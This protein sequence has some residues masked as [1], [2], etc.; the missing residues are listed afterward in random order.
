MS[1]SSAQA[2]HSFVGLSHSIP[3]RSCI[4]YQHKTFIVQKHQSHGSTTNL[5]CIGITHGSERTCGTI[6]YASASV[7]QVQPRLFIN[8]IQVLKTSTSAKARL[9][10]HAWYN[11]PLLHAS[12]SPSIFLETWNPL[13]P[14]NPLNMTTTVDANYTRSNWTTFKYCFVVGLGAI[15][16]GIDTGCMVG[17]FANGRYANT[18]FSPC[19]IDHD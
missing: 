13:N 17:F 12:M 16:F 14:L 6:R 1:N 9:A 11:S 7:P 19:L 8:L 2:G 5:S 15:L 18:K 3:A 10:Y 4:S